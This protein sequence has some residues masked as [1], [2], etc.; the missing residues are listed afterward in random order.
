MPNDPGKDS[1]SPTH[2]LYRDTLIEQAEQGWTTS[3]STPACCSGCPAHRERCPLTPDIAPC[4]DHTTS[5]I[6]AAHI[7]W[8]GTA[9]PCYVT[10]KVHLG[11][12][13]R[14]DVKQGHG[15]EGG[16]VPGGGWGDLRA[17]VRVGSLR[18][19]GTGR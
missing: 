13:D 15:G 8:Y 19:K 3:P 2:Q 11:L 17:G 6:G 9:M 18:L 7:G 5:A 10:P 12:P 16:G 14:D 1:S 4:Y